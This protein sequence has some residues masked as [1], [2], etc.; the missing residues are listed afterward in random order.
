M[1]ACVITARASYAK[2]ETILEHLGAITV[3]LCGSALLDRYGSLLSAIHG[4]SRVVPVYSHVDGGL[5]ISAAL[6]AGQLLSQLAS[7]LHRDK[8]DKLM[9]MADRSEVL[10]AAQ[11]AAYLNIPV[12]HIQGG[13]KTGSIDDRVRDAISHLATWHF[14]ATN[15]AK[16]RVYSMTG[17]DNI[18]MTGCPSIDI[19]KRALSEPP[20]TAAELSGSGADINPLEPFVLLLH[21]SDTDVWEQSF[22][23]MS[24][25][26]RALEHVNFP[27]L[28]QWPNADA[29]TERISKAIRVYRDR[30]R[31]QIRSIPNMAPIRFLRLCAQSSALVGNSSVGV[32]EGSYL[33]VPVVN[34]GQRQYGRE[35]GPNVVDVGYDEQVITEVVQAQVAHVRYSSVTLYGDGE[36]GRRIA[37]V[38]GA[39]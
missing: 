35:R 23:Q 16:W 32:R 10:A 27:V 34:V 26:L 24:T 9:V 2:F 7:H 18:H 13:E 12:A 19:A 15:R 4:K 14:P 5:P 1:T 21:H 6:S 11:A 8:P 25:I 30:T 3:Y 22:Q 31:L 29:G 36:A 39:V 37:E 28:V 20:V 33:G 38:L 17:S